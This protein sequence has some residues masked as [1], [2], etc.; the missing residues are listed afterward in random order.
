VI[1]QHQLLDIAT[2]TVV[3]CSLL[4]T[5][6]P[7][8]DFLN[9]FPTAQKYYKVFVYLVGYIGLNARSTVYQSVSMKNQMNIPPSAPVPSAQ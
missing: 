8:W 2:Q 6:L 4:H 7:P 1:T 5:F 9:D 3:A